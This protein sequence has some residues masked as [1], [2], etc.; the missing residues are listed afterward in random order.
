[1]IKDTMYITNT[2]GRKTKEGG[3]GP[4]NISASAVLSGNPDKL[5]D[6]E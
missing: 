5:L 3:K 6:N 4:R 2:G 1:M